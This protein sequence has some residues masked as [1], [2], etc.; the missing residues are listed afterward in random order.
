MLE[1]LK[2][3][4][5]GKE[6]EVVAEV[7]QAQEV[8][9]TPVIKPSLEDADSNTTLIIAALKRHDENM[10]KRLI[11]LAKEES[12]GNL[13]SLLKAKL[14]TNLDTKLATN[15]EESVKNIEMTARLQQVLDMIKARGTPITPTELASELNIK[16]P[17][18]YAL[19]ER[20]VGLGLIRKI[21]RGNYEPIL[22]PNETNLATKLDTN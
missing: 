10:V 18:A 20:L 9:P 17:S 5:R 4:K 13:I 1:R 6:V 8:Q 19:L 3:W 7:K 14:G 16:P 12:L 22:A 21:E 15:I 11:P 2:F